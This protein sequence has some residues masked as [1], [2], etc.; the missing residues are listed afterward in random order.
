MRILPLPLAA[1]SEDG[2]MAQKLIGVAPSA[3]YENDYIVSPRFLR[4]ARASPARPRKILKKTKI[5]D[6]FLVELQIVVDGHHSK[7]FTAEEDLVIYMAT[8]VAMVNIR[9]ANS[10][11]PTEV[12]SSL[13]WLLK[14]EKGCESMLTT[15]FKAHL[16]TK[17]YKLKRDH[18]FY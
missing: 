4:K 2:R 18:E 11:N 15:I 8:M 5:P 13:R 12:K 17:N 3:H 10:Q 14:F 16:P 7:S 6:P 1:K 9:Y